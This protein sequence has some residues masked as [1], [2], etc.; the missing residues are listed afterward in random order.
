MRRPI[1]QEPSIPADLV[2]CCI[3]R[4]TANFSA[5][6]LR[7]DGMVGRQ[8]FRPCPLYL[9]H[10]RPQGRAMADS[11]DATVPFPT[12]TFLCAYTSGT[13]VYCSTAVL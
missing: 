13:I 8:F 1:H 6:S 4:R 7:L 11:S 2:H 5:L 10:D 12:T 9:V 3:H